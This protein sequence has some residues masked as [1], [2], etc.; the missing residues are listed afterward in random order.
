MG[1]GLEI[2]CFPEDAVDL[3]GLIESLGL[4]QFYSN[5]LFGLLVPR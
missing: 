2:L 1:E 4:H 3:G 5:C